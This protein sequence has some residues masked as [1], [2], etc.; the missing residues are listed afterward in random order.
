MG[1]W[2]A[3][4]AGRR[5]V[6]TVL[7]HASPATATCRSLLVFVFP[8]APFLSSCILMKSFPVHL[9]DSLPCY[10]SPFHLFHPSLHPLLPRDHRKGHCRHL[11]QF[12]HLPRA[13]R[14][15]GTPE[16]GRQSILIPLI[17]ESLSVSVTLSLSSA[18]L[19]FLNCRPLR[20]KNGGNGL[21]ASFMR[22]ETQRDLQEMTGKKCRK[23]SLAICRLT[24]LADT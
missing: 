12:L 10:F 24:H 11:Q 16:A 9:S 15:E 6:V 22:P 7:S 23:K 17:F 21:L 4:G 18:F 3:V 2:R 13:C 14:A 5:Q 20:D 19:I 8:R 1:L